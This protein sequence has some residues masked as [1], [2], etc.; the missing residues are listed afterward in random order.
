[1]EYYTRCLA[2]R[3]RIGEPSGLATVIGNLGCVLEEMGQ[4]DS[5]LVHHRRHLAMRLR[6]G[7]QEWLPICYSNLGACFDKLGLSDSALHYL[8]VAL[9]LF[10]ERERSGNARCTAIGERGMA[11][12]HVGRAADALIACKEALN[13]ALAFGDLPMQ[14]KCY[15]CLYQAYRSQGNAPRALWA[16][17]AHVAVRD[18]IRGEERAKDLTRIELTYRFNQQL[19]MDSLVRIEER[20]QAELTSERRVSHERDQKRVFL[21]GGIGLL[22]LAGGLWSRLRHTNRS[23]R[24]IRLE[25]D[26]S[27]KLL[28]NI[29]PGTV[30]EEL[31]T[32]GRAEARSVEGVSVLFTDFLGFTSLCERLSARELVQEVDTCFRAF[33]GI[34]AKHRIEKIKTIGDAYMC[35]GGL[36][37]P[38]AHS[39]RDTVLAALEMQEWLSRRAAS[40][41]SQPKPIF[42]MR[43]GIHTGQ[44]VAG[45]VGDSK[46]QYDIWGDTVNTA[47]RLENAGIAGEVNISAATYE[48]IKDCPGF[49]FTPRGLVEV[50]GKGALQMYY[51]RRAL[52]TSPADQAAHPGSEEV[53]DATLT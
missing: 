29:L 53:R 32:H 44:V 7:Q 27:D 9:E 49:T 17:L 10:T 16:H 41:N 20:H 1:M 12:L 51:V 46:F 5:A 18:S 43:V 8:D 2:I 28:L 25:R 30:A 39:A 19:L 52:Q 24:L 47:A 35:A 33:D 37:G 48:E 42:A 21:F 6:A 14:E 31:K 45:I 50:K 13:L 26:R 23:Q 38:R 11:L 3:Q 36:P 34:V 15:N 4:L 40:Q 22:I